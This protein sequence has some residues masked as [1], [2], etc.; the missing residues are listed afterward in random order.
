MDKRKIENKGLP[1]VLFNKIVEANLKC[2]YHNHFDLYL[3]KLGFK[4]AEVQVEVQEFHINPRD[5][6]H[7]AVAYALL[8][9]AM[10][11]AI[12]TVNRNVVT[13][14]SSMNH[15]AVSRLG[16]YFRPGPRL[17]NMGKKKL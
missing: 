14:Q 4:E 1:E 16:I 9:T 7:G 12:R 17:L 3:T 10:G 2:N 5:I 6:S 11:M 15:T 13:I 8:D